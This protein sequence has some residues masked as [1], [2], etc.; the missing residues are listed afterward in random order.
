MTERHEKKERVEDIGHF[1]KDSGGRIEER[2]T[3]EIGKR[4]EGEKGRGERREEAGDRESKTE[5]TN[6]SRR[7]ENDKS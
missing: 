2:S 7:T 6:R 4:S 5:V 3:E 1:K